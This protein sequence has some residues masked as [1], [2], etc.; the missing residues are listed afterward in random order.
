MK[1][2]GLFVC[3]TLALMLACAGCATSPEDQER[4][5]A[6]AEEVESILSQPLD[7]SEYG[8]TKRCLAGSEYRDFR[9]LDDQR[10]CRG[11]AREALAQYPAHALPR[12][13]IR[14]GAAVKS[15][16]S[17]GRICDMDSFS[18]AIGSTGPGTDVGPG[19]GEPLGYRHDV[20]PRQISA[21]H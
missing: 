2:N 12:L 5:R 19:L 13:T 10:I 18:P 14:Y 7:S 6:T 17:Y 21:G 11:S 15:I 4:A 20:Q 8:Q 9:V 16:Y 1:I 3:V